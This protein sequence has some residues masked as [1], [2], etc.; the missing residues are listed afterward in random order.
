MEMIFPEGFVWGVATSAYQIEGAWNED[1][2]GENIWDRYSHRLGNVRNHDNGDI[3]VDHYHRMPADVALM[4]TL[5]LKAYRFSVSWA[6]V[7]PEGRG[8]A[9]P[10]GL[11]FYDR[12]VDELLQAGIQPVACLYHW[13]LPQA[14]YELG[15]WPARQTT[16]FYTDYARLMFDRL[17]DRVQTWDTFNEPRVTCFLGYGQ[18]VMAPGIAD[19]SLAY[20]TAHHLLLAHGKAVQVFRQGGY[21]GKIGII[22]DSE[23]SRPASDCDEDHAA[24]QR[25]YEYDTLFFT[26]ALF[27]GGYPASHLEWIGPMAPRILAG[28]METIQQP[29]DFLGVNYYR[30][31]LISF[32]PQGGYLKYRSA[33]RTL[34]E[35]GY[36]ELGWGIYPA[37]LKGVLDSLANRYT[38]PEL[39]ITENGC[40]VRDEPDESGFVM[41]RKRIQFLHDHIAAAYEAIQAGVNLRGYFV[42]SLLDNFEWS[43]GYTPSFGLVRVDY[44]TLKRIPRQ[45]YFWYQRVIAANGL[46]GQ[47]E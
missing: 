44:A 5:G 36:T 38:L 18:A 10:A 35:Y 40:A 20:Q 12:L 29:L 45:S 27:N 30:A 26:D 11:G 16:D 23:Y 9:N 39:Y 47:Y 37:G 21:Q 14:I 46:V 28:D 19:A 15:G 32:D 7:L 8:R 31:T 17:G 33:H 42:W 43:E 4:H 1:G 22:L 41:D 34:P 13:D 3:A 2:K 6:R 24:W 25:Y